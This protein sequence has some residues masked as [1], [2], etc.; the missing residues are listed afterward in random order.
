M[1]HFIN[2][3][4]KIGILKKDLDYHLIRASLVIIF[5]I[6]PCSRLPPEHFYWLLMAS[7]R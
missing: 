5:L 4:V 2:L 6:C 1:R 7:P 3:L